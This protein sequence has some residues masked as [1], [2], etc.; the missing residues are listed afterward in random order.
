MKTEELLRPRYK[1]TNIWP[2]MGRDR[3]HQGQIIELS[4][5]DKEQWCKVER[6]LTT[7]E[8]FYIQYPHLFEPLPWWKDRKL[9]EMPVY[10]KC[11]ATPDQRIMPG[12]VLKITE[13]FASG[14]GRSGEHVVFPYTNC[15]DPATKEEYEAYLNT[16]NQLN[17]GT[18]N[19]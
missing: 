4:I 13:W 15:F 18:E 6:D 5:K 9:E 10:V 11:T 7:Y 16:T 3:Y 17:N 1:V 14:C 12:M 2:D 19:R 8:A